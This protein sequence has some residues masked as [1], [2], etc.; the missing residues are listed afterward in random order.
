M[1]K[2]AVALLGAS[3]TMGHAAFKE[4]W[5]RRHDYDIVL[6]SVGWNG[7]TN[8]FTL[9][10]RT[11]M[12]VIDLIAYPTPF[13]EDV[14]I[15]YRLA[16]RGQSVRVRVYSVAGRR[17]WE[18]GSAPGAPDANTLWWD[19][20]DTRGRLVANGTYLVHVLAT[21]RNGSAEATTTTV[22]LR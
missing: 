22:K 2:P 9:R 21:G 10:V 19:G 20:R 18:Q 17:V 1:T 3:G 4:L 8:N 7:A 13:V 6:E 16:T 12:E 11:T 5:A 15:Y 14:G